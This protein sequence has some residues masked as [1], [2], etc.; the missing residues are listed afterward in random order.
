MRSMISSHNLWVGDSIA[1]AI[2]VIIM[3]ILYIM[4]GLI[5]LSGHIVVQGVLVYGLKELLGHYN[6]WVAG[7]S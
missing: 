5:E 2:A 4:E 3:G 6:L 7:P 1:I